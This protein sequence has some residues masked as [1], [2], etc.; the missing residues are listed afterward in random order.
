MNVPG[1]VC[2]VTDKGQCLRA[3][4]TVV[5]SPFVSVRTKDSGQ[6]SYLCS[7]SKAGAMMLAIEECDSGAYLTH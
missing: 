3:N 7:N 5:H 1:Q 2:D 6:C 4:F